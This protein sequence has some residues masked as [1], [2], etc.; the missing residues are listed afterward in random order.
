MGLPAGFEITEPFPALYHDGLDAVIIA[1]LHIGIEVV[2]TRQGIMFPKVQTEQIGEELETIQDETG[3]SRL[4]VA[5][6]VKHSFGAKGQQQRDEVRRFFDG[7]SPMFEEI[8]L[9]RGNHD[10][11]LDSMTKDYTNIV[12]RD[13]FDKDGICI[14]HGHEKVEDEVETLVFGHEHP[15]VELQDQAGVTEKIHCFLVGEDPDVIVLPAF[16]PLASGTEV[17]TVPRSELLSPLLRDR[18]DIEAMQVV[19]ID[20]DAGKLPFATLGELMTAQ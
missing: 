18:F 3:A 9:V 4:I 17:N 6:D 15:A 1:D 19:G 13:R 7:I 20:R 16:S 5:G 10:T 14:V 12:V 8:V 11:G 2:T